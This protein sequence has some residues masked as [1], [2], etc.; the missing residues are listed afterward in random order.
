MSDPIARL[1][2]ARAAVDRLRDGF[3]GQ[4]AADSGAVATGAT[5]E[6][7]AAGRERP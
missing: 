4:S 1:S 5:G 7:T 3:S 6:A 2:A